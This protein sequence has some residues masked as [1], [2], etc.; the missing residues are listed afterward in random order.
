M[1]NEREQVVTARLRNGGSVEMTVHVEPWGEQFAMPPGATFEV[2]ARGPGGDDL[3]ITL[4]GD[5]VTLW[6]WAGSVVTL[7]Q[8]G[9]ELRTAGERQG[10]PASHDV[11]APAGE[12]RAS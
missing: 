7:T 5:S 6:G 8:R 2:A 9:V 10:A 11:A 3:E 4:D 12:S 1:G